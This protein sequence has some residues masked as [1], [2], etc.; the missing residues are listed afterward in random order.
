MEV[1]EKSYAEACVGQNR[2]LC[3]FPVPLLLADR[4]LAVGLELDNVELT[5]CL[6]VPR[7]SSGLLC[8]AEMPANGDSKFQVDNLNTHYDKAS[9]Q[10]NMS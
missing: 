9:R 6:L 4:L 3:R 5:A 7:C 10:I 2:S 8:F 1:R